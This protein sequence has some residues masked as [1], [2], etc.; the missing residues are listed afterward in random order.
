LL[1]PE[2]TARR[3]PIAVVIDV[4]AADLFCTRIDG[5]VF[6]IAVARAHRTI[7]LPGLTGADL[8][9]SLSIAIAILIQVEGRAASGI[10]GIGGPITVIIGFSLTGFGGIW[11]D[12]SIGIVT[13]QVVCDGPLRRKTG[14]LGQVGIAIPVPIGIGP[15]LLFGALFFHGLLCPRPP[16]QFLIGDPRASK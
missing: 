10:H 8:F 1:T 11:M 5:F 16:R 7:G 13:V 15:H 6:V 9:I 3:P 14:V 12:L 4:I 2:L